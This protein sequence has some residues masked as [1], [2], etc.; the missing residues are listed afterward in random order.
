M[1]DIPY[2]LVDTPFYTSSN[3]PQLDGLPTNKTIHYTFV[4]NTFMM[5]NLFNQINSR[6]LG[7]RD[8]NVFEG[9]F[10]NYLFLIILGGEFAGQWFLVELGGKVFRTTPQPFLLIL[11]SFIFGAGSLMVCALLKLIPEEKLQTFPFLKVN[12]P[13]EK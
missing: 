4:F 12:L 7:A 3:N 13:E 9:F 1:Y 8:F 2:N 11:S 6:K 5:M 10:N